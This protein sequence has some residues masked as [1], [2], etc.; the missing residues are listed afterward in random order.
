MSPGGYIFPPKL[1][2]TFKKRIHFAKKKKKTNPKT[3]WCSRRVYYF[4]WPPYSRV[5]MAGHKSNFFK[6]NVL[7][8]SVPAQL[9]NILNTCLIFA[10]K[11]RKSVSMHSLKSLPTLSLKHWELCINNALW[12]GSW[13]HKYQYCWVNKKHHGW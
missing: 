2:S 3:Y 8:I 6:M 9:G 5:H 12:W 10:K 4:A 13:H 11:W 1:S 7:N